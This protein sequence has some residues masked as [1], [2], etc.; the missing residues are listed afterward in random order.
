MKLLFSLELSSFGHVVRLLFVF[1]FDERHVCLILLAV[2]FF[3][4]LELAFLFG[5]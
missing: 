2:K 1:T 4:L 3:K 5:D